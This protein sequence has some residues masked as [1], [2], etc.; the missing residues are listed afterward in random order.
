MAETVGFVGLGSMGLPMAQRVLAAGFALRVYNRTA[1]K[2]AELLAQGAQG[3]TTPAETVTP[4][5][6]V[7]TMLA[8]DAALEAVT[9]GE[10]G[11]LAALGPGGVHLSMSTV[12]PP[13]ARR[14]ADA[15]GEHDVAS[16]MVLSW[17]YASSMRTLL[18]EAGRIAPVGAR[19]H[20]ITGG[21]LGGPFATPWRVDGGL[22]H[23][24]GPHV[25]DSLDAA[26]N[27]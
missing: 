4:G 11:F 24:L 14:L 19:G 8:N 7:V 18:L 6:I 3:A 23:D 25:I 2:A 26:R 16:Q 9:L 5:G 22:L 17:R 1:D 10:G 27:Q 13:L 15:I 20:L 12:S 21:G